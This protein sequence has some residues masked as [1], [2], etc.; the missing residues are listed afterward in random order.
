MK[1]NKLLLLLFI[2]VIVSVSSC[3]KADEKPEMETNPVINTKTV[4]IDDIVEQTD[5]FETEVIKN[6][7]K[8]WG[9]VSVNNALWFWQN[10]LNLRYAYPE[11]PSNSSDMKETNISVQ[12]SNGK[13]S[14]T[15]LR[16]IFAQVLAITGDQFKVTGG[17]DV[18]SKQLHSGY[19]ELVSNDG[20]NG[21]ANIK[22]ISNI[23]YDDGNVYE[24]KD[25][26]FY[27][28]DDWYW[29]CG[30]GPYD[31]T[32]NP[33]F[34]NNS[35]DATTEITRC[36][37]AHFGLNGYTVPVFFANLVWSEITDPSYWEVS[38][39]APF[40]NMQPWL[41]H[42]QMNTEYNNYVDHVQF[43][44]DYGNQVPLTDVRYSYL[45]NGN[46]PS[47][48]MHRGFME[49]AYPIPLPPAIYALK[50]PDFK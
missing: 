50:I 46:L 17:A 1:I 38:P 20:G 21:K 35:P 26:P 43:Y 36:A 23:R 14:F 33:D 34:T 24:A 42:T 30:F 19:F 9:G 13:V 47:F 6:Q 22:Y 25:N 16:Q 44:V 39:W 37:I 40:S 18:A 28:G 45:G 10:Y 2:G 49:K 15:E 12:L 27:S 4:L 48:A 7:E 8:C 5:W 32:H 41:N 31:G 11:L 29:G 3:K